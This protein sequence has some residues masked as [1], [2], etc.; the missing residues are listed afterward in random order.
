M[1]ENITRKGDETPDLKRRSS[2]ASLASVGSDTSSSSLGLS[3]GVRFKFVESLSQDA[4]QFAGRVTSLRHG[5]IPAAGKI[6][7]RLID[8]SRKPVPDELLDEQ[9]KLEELGVTEMEHLGKFAL[10][11]VV[12]WRKYILSIHCAC[13]T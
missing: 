11:M 12:Q 13:V 9:D 4:A 3:R 10:S 6:L 8:Q 1:Y 7:D 5:R 2:I